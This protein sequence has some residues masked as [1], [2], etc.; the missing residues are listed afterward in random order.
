M[1]AA[2]TARL[3]RAAGRAGH[4]ASL[5]P[6][7]TLLTHEDEEIAAAAATALER[8]TGAGLYEVVE[9]PWELALP[10]AA[11][12]LGPVPTP[13][14][15]VRRVRRDP[16]AWRARCAPLLSMGP[17]A[18]PNPHGAGARACGRARRTAHA[19]AQV[20]S[21]EAL[22]PFARGR[23]DRLAEHTPRRARR[24]AART[25]DRASPFVFVPAR[26]VGRAAAEGAAGAARERGPLRVWSRRVS[27]AWPGARPRRPRGARARGA[28]HDHRRR[29]HRRPAPHVHATGSNVG[30]RERGCSNGDARRRREQRRDDA[31]TGARSLE[32]GAALRLERE[33]H[34]DDAR[35]GARSPEPGAALRLEREQHRDDARTGARSPEP[36]AALRLE[37]EQHRDDA[38]TSA[39]SP[40][41]GAA[42]RLER[43]QH[44]DDAR[45]GARSPEP[46]AALRLEREQ[47]RDD[48]RTG[49]RSPEPGAAS[50]PTMRTGRPRR[51]LRPCPRDRDILRRRP[52]NSRRKRWQGGQRRVAL[53]IRCDSRSASTPRCAPT[54]RGGPTRRRRRSPDMASPTRARGPRQTEH[55]ASASHRIPPFTSSGRPST[56]GAWRRSG[57]DGSHVVANGRPGA[58]ARRG[59]RDAWM[60][61]PNVKF[62]PP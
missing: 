48:A 39:R 51:A 33:Q 47:H 37:R 13:T 28:R 44:R 53:P 18:A 49:A 24:S 26:H 9:E 43:E 58:S 52:A 25:G 16:G 50:A 45:T 61:R 2:P 41:P 19:R 31:G 40:E 32:P 30:R 14:R 17:Q 23:R 20:A 5:D 27:G 8:I 46:G 21:W 4:A 34:R 57:A 54:W 59:R 60:D 42:L 62:A 35:T 3:A 29:T 7:V 6:L 12:E 15:K 11:R 36:G 22:H 38:R 55:G 1:S 56:T 10:P